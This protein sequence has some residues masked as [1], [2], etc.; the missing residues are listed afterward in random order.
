[1][2]II[3]KTKNIDTY[4]YN[5]VENYNSVQVNNCKFKSITNIYN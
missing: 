4:Q 5:N 1:M 3:Y 2:S